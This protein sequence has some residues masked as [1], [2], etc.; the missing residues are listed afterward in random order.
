M[1]IVLQ[2]SMLIHVSGRQHTDL[3]CHAT[4]QIPGTHALKLDPLPQLPRPKKHGRVVHD[5][6]RQRQ[7]L[8][9]GP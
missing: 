3:A 2:Y 4:D 1:P 8:P 6:A 7:P 5:G 9:P